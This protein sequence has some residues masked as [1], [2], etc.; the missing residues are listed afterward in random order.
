MSERSRQACFDPEEHKRE[1][2][3]KKQEKLD[4]IRQGISDTLICRCYF[5]YDPSY[6]YYYPNAVNDK[7]I[8]G[9]EE[10]DFILDGYC[11]RRISQLTK[12]EI[13]DDKCNEI[14]RLFGL[15]NQII[16]PEIDMSSWQ[17]IFE[18]L[19]RLD[20]YIEIED[21]INE[22]FAI[23]VIEKIFKD[24]LLFRLFDADGIWDD[25]VWEIRYSQ[26]TSVKWGTRYAEHWKR[27]LE[28]LQR[29]MPPAIVR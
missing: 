22:Q 27:Y 14:N 13:K 8:L 23:G 15:T 20:T 21:A 3:M 26:I 11:I 19:I 7:F 28:R 18:S 29:A 17:S 25:D 10:D 12:V 4:V 5:A 16:D 24:R 1:G 6:F 9:Q 2:I